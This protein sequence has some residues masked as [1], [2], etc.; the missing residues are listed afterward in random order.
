MRN[1]F[2]TRLLEQ[3]KK[4]LNNADDGDDAAALAD[5]DNL[6]QS[7]SEDNEEIPEPDADTQ[8]A[9][10]VESGQAV[11]TFP[12]EIADIPGGVSALDYG[13]AAKAAMEV[14]L[15][16]GTDQSVL[17]MGCSLSASCASMV[18]PRTMKSKANYGKVI[19]SGVTRIL[20]FIR[21][22]SSSHAVLNVLLATMDSKASSMSSVQRSEHAGGWYDGDFYG[23]A[24]VKKKRQNEDREQS[25]RRS[26]LD[27]TTMIFSEDK[28]LQHPLPVISKY[29]TLSANLQHGS[30]PDWVSEYMEQAGRA[31]AYGLPAPMDVSEL[32]QRNAI[33]NGISEIESQPTL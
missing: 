14:W 8:F 23:S 21:G 1:E 19:I 28:E 18:V 5:P 6:D 17:G 32:P 11:E 22:L 25:Y 2:N 3:A 13:D 27:D 26:S 33:E 12:D 4:D 9:D 30:D 24:V 10:Q 7:F 29:P 15:S 20:T 16:V 31:L